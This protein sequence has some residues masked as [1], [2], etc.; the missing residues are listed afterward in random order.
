M[1]TG[2]MVVDVK[3]F[4]WNVISQGGVVLVELEVVVDDRRLGV[5]RIFSEDTIGAAQVSF[6]QILADGPQAKL[7]GHLAAEAQWKESR[8]QMWEQQWGS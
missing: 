2:G 7:A 8:G 5:K 6:F 4:E 3:D 1:K